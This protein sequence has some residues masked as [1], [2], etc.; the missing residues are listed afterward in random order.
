MTFGSFGR[1]V[2]HA[3]PDGSIRKLIEVTVDA[4]GYIQIEQFDPVEAGTADIV[5]LPYQDIPWLVEQLVSIMAERKL[6][7][8]ANYKPNPN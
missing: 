4:E 5:T 3:R 7:P 2:H 1:C 6:I 8:D